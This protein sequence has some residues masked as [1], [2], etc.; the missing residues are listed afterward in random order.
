MLVWGICQRAYWAQ[1]VLGT[2]NASHRMLAGGR[3]GCDG[4]V[5]VVGTIGG[6]RHRTGDA[7]CTIASIPLML[8]HPP[9]CRTLTTCMTLHSKLF[10]YSNLS[11]NLLHQF[12]EAP[13]NKSPPLFGH[14]PNSIYTPPPHSN[15]HS[16]AFFFR[17][18]FTILPFLRFFLTFF[19]HFL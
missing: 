17:R 10:S 14:C 4:V 18:D 9:L 15:G 12:R 3:A 7:S 2:S 6:H 1:H 11:N 16:G 8:A 19:Y 5:E 13:F